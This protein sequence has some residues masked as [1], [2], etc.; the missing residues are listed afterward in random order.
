ETLSTLGSANMQFCC[1]GVVSSSAHQMFAEFKPSY[2]LRQ[3][4]TRVGFPGASVT[5]PLLAGSD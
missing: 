3:L 4:G 5:L 2:P 1:L